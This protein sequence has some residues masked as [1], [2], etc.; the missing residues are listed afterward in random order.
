MGIKGASEGQWLVDARVGYGGKPVAG[1]T[2]DMK[3]GE[4]IS[5]IGPDFRNPYRMTRNPR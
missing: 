2:I 4:I 5:P 3:S 1:F